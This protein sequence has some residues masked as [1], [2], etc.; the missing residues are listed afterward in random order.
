MNP[1]IHL[2]KATPSFVVPFVL[3]WFNNTTGN[4]NTAIGR[5]ALYSN[6][7]GTY[8]TAYG[9]GA[10]EFNTTGS[11]NT[12][13]GFQALFNNTTGDQLDRRR[14]YRYAGPLH[15]PRRP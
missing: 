3:A 14:A 6:T 8:N 2:K 1:L 7:T 15:K 11:D 5:T 13:I 12:A 4:N 10:L 9:S